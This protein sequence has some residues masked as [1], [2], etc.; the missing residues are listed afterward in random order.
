LTS[1]KLCDSHIIPRHFIRKRDAG[2]GL[3]E[4]IDGEPLKKRLSKGWTEYLLCEKC[5]SHLGR[6]DDYAARF[7]A[8][9]DNWG[10]VDVRQIDMRIFLVEEFN[11]EL[12]KLFFMS[13]LWRSAVASIP[14]FESVALNHKYQEE[15]REMILRNDPGDEH[16]YGTVI[17][18]YE[19]HQKGYEKITFTPHEF[20]QSN[21]VFYYQLQLNEFPCHIKVSNQKDAARYPGFWLS[22]KPP[23][24]IME[25]KLLP[26]RLNEMVRIVQTQ[27]KLLEE[28]RLKFQQHMLKDDL[29]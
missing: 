18:K 3:F 28:F 23:L 8:T 17:F 26:T 22:K 2:T 9:S 13:L 11:Y 10:I 4:F 16:K 20:R 12:L 27:P 19:P 5:E 25:V 7:F 1:G 14:A 15:L 29:P 24:R 21:C 6:F